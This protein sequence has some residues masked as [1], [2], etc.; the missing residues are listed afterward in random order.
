MSTPREDSPGKICVFC[1]ADCASRPRT[2][3]SRGR[4]YCQP[5]YQQAL[6]EARARPAAPKAA[7]SAPPRPPQ[8][9]PVRPAAPARR[10]AP[11]R[12]PVAIAPADGAD[13]LADLMELETA[14]AALPEGAV[15]RGCGSAL[16]PGAVLCTN[17]G[18]N[19]K[20]GR[21]AAAAAVAE[22]AVQAAKAKTGGGL[23]LD[24]VT[25]MLTTPL[26]ATAIQAL[27]VLAVFGV[28]K[29]SD[30]LAAPALILL[31]VYSLAVGIWVLVSA[32]REG[33]GTGLLCLCV[34]F[35]ALYFV[36]VKNSNPH[37]KGAFGVSVLATI[38]GVMLKSALP[39]M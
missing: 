35:Y 21:Q 24:G 28:A 5:C 10:P 31:Q 32:F 37:L 39:G 25:G 16:P 9:P 4:Y 22:P 11:A 30:G 33:V 27:I 20:T 34:P 19:L 36:L 13:A 26:G 1:G 8:A 3:D 6:K 38:C 12:A 18:L 7:P 29:S 14:A 15:C 23:K 17:C 2:K